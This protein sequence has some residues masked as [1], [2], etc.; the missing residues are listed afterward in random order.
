LLKK[1]QPLALWRV[2]L[3][4]NHNALVYLPAKDNVE[5]RDILASAKDG[6]L[7]RAYLFFESARIESHVAEC[8]GIWYPEAVERS[9][10]MLAE[11]SVVTKCQVIKS[12]QRN[13][14][15]AAVRV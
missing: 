14:V 1:L 9:I 12:A 8:V 6:G 10:A 3:A 2:F 5:H 13:S 7:R 11:I 15:L 4:C